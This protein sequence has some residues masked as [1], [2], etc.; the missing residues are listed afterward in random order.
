MVLPLVAGLGLLGGCGSDSTDAPKAQ[1]DPW[2]REREQD[3]A[4][5]VNA[6]DW[7]A[8]VQA[9]QAQAW[10]ARVGASAL[11]AADYAA[12]V[13]IGQAVRAAEALAAAK[14]AAAKA[15]AAK[16]KA[17]AKG[18]APK[19]KTVAKAAPPAKAKAQSK[20]AP[21]GGSGI[22]SAQAQFDAFARK[23]VGTI[24]RN[25]RHTAADMALK[26][27]GGGVVARFMEVD[28]GSLELQV[29]P[30]ASGGA[31]C[32]YVGVLRYQEHHYEARAASEAEVRQGPFTRVKTQ[33]VTEIF[34]YVSGR[35]TN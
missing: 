22:E 19:A 28:H 33:R 27:D 7:L 16:G 18:A 21:K 25:L 32:P 5:S 12:Q 9:G 17:A 8:T 1:A 26:H 34:R 2:A 15:D 30:S 14:E 10:A 31:S 23:W 4:A 13:R 29:K 6:T 3:W 11:A 20:A 24:S 35:W